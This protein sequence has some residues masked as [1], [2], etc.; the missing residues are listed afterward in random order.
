MCLA[1]YVELIGVPS[2]KAAEIAAHCSA[3]S[4]LIVRSEHLKETSANCH[5]SI[6]EFSDG[7][8]CSMLADNAA[9]EATT[10]SLRPHVL[11]KLG[12]VL[13]CLLARTRFG[14][15]FE[16]A[17]LGGDD[18]PTE[19]RISVRELLAVVETGDI[20]TKTRYLT[21]T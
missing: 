7:C 12:A 13:R 16:A 19:V 18:E 4:D 17:W 11:P 8:A 6:R 14:V 15:V 1:L 9:E 5:F 21:G 20:K 2:Q 3:T 10:W